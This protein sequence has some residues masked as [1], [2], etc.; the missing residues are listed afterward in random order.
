MK[1]GAGQTGGRELDAI[2][3]I[4]L[5]VAG[6]AGILCILIGGWLCYRGTVGANKGEV[7]LQTLSIKWQFAGPGLAVVALGIALVIVAVQ[8]P[9]SN[10]RHMTTT[11]TTTTNSGQVVT[12]VTTSEEETSTSNAMGLGNA[13]DVNNSG[14]INAT[15]TNAF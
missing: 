12:T 6:I 4:K 3:I 10:N 13:M 14:P 1:C 2:A 8:R 9:M 15:G 11:T 5:L 7:K